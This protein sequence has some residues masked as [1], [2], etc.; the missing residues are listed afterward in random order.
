MMLLQIRRQPAV[1]S[2]HLVTQRLNSQWSQDMSISLAALELL[3]GLAKVKVGVD[4]ADRKRAVSSICSYI[5]YQCSR[6][7]PLQSRDLHS[8][9]VAAFQF[10]CVWLTEHPDMLDEKDCL[11][12]VLEIVELGI[13]GSKSRHEQE[14]RHKAEKEH[15]PASMRV[16]DAA[17]ATL[18]CIMQVLGA[19]P[20][21]SGPASTA[22]C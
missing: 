17:E 20:S 4:S 6:P 18:S 16:K 13:S 14:V 19:F 9:I 2:I 7:A 22:A 5:V 21:P 10:L 3:A 1:R 11:M 8:M 15:N 12:E